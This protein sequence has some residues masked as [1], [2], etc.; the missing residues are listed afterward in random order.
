MML[1]QPAPSIPTPTTATY[2]TQQPFP[3]HQPHQQSNIVYHQQPTGPMLTPMGFSPMGL[4]QPTNMNMNMATMM[5]PPQT[6]MVQ[7]IVAQPTPNP[8]LNT[9]T[10]QPLPTAPGQPTTMFLST[11]V[12]YNSF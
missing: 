1:Q 6:N 7:M 11:P 4:T 10:N 3:F 2:L 12:Y 8:N 9:T 5:H